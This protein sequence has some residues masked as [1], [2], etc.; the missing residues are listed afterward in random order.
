MK[1]NTHSRGV[2]RE[3]KD[4]V[5]VQT[6]LFSLC[7]D[8]LSNTFN[9]RTRISHRHTTTVLSVIS[10]SLRHLSLLWQV[11]Y[12]SN[13]IKQRASFPSS[14]YS[15]RPTC[16]ATTTTTNCWPLH[17]HREMMITK[18]KKKEI[19]CFPIVITTIERERLY[20]SDKESFA[21]HPSS[22]CVPFFGLF[23]FSKS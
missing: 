10:L 15:Y 9:T 21:G 12:Y 5:V 20:K 22:C 3:R 1:Y 23:C 14:S 2:Q 11:Y 17:I 6:F 8:S 7:P 13:I 4:V 16:Y 18:K 19:L